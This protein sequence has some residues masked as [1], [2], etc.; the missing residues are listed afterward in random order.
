MGLSGA[1]LQEK[2]AL[3]DEKYSISCPFFFDKMCTFLWP[4]SRGREKIGIEQ[5]RYFFIHQVLLCLLNLGV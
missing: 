1:I 4:Y 3:K 5:L 2:S